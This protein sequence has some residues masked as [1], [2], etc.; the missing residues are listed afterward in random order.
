MLIYMKCDTKVLSRPFLSSQNDSD[1]HKSVSA[2]EKFMRAHLFLK[3]S[4]WMP[5]IWIT[6]Y[7]AV[8]E[9]LIENLSLWH[10]KCLQVSSA[11]G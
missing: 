1:V 6:Y 3:D 2:F 5:T 4:A 8:E 7:A 9:K 10:L 11:F